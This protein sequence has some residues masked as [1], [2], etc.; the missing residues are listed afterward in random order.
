MRRIAHVDS[1]LFLVSFVADKMPVGHLGRIVAV[2]AVMFRRAPTAN[3][4]DLPH[5]NLGVSPSLR[6]ACSRLTLPPLSPPPLSLIGTSVLT[7]VITTKLVSNS[8][9]LKLIDSLKDVAGTICVE[10]QFRAAQ[11]F[12]KVNAPMIDVAKRSSWECVMGVQSG[13]FEAYIG[14]DVILRWVRVGRPPPVVK[15]QPGR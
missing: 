8:V 13:E 6:A 9:P 11:D 3:T 15:S 4:Q 5:L 2:L 14:D 7:S 10:A 12:L 1:R